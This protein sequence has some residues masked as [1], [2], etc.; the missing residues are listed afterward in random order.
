MQGRIQGG[1]SGAKIMDWGGQNVVCPPLPN[2][3]QCYKKPYR[4]ITAN[5]RFW[6]FLAPSFENCWIRPYTHASGLRFR[7][8]FFVSNGPYD[9]TGSVGAV[10]EGMTI[11]IA[12]GRGDV[13]GYENI[14]KSYFFCVQMAGLPCT[15]H[16][17]ICTYSHCF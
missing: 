3:T 17:H 7:I 5:T 12:G 2:R 6:P 16:H 4:Y 15:F 10:D 14:T 11:A 9:S 1:A 13:T 8:A